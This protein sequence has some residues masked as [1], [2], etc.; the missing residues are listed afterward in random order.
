MRIKNDGLESPAIFNSK[1]FELRIGARATRI[2]FPQ[3]IARLDNGIPDH[4]V[5]E[6]QG[7]TVR[8]YAYFFL[9]NTGKFR[10]IL[11]MPSVIV[12]R[13]FQMLRPISQQVTGASPDCVQSACRCRPRSDKAR[14]LCCNPAQSA[15]QARKTDTQGEKHESSTEFGFFFGT[16]SW[17]CN[18]ARR[19]GSGRKQGI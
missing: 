12:T 4:V 15:K 14:R 13:L 2:Q 6:T 1:S 19:L 5:A 8:I 3:I 17:F 16:V 9:E 11:R 18:S 10:S 7:A